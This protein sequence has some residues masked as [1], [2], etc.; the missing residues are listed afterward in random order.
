MTR[1]IP[2][3]LLSAS[4]ASYTE[5]CRVLNAMLQRLVDADMSE[6]TFLR[7]HLTPDIHLTPDNHLTPG[8][9]HV[10]HHIDRPGLRVARRLE[11]H[12]QRAGLQC[13]PP[14]ATNAGRG[15]AESLEGCVAGYV[16]GHAVGRQH[17]P[18]EVGRSCPC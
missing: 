10:M 4:A 2:A 5:K 13:A 6:P 16:D 12:G 3:L 8:I 14:M 15:A 9:H 18:V 11:T 1:G 7:Q 17:C